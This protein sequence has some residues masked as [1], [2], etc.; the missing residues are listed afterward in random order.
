MSAT[1]RAICQEH[2][3]MFA[4][5][6]RRRFLT[7]TTG[8][9]AGSIFLGPTGR[10]AGLLA[11]SGRFKLSVITDEITQDFA[12]ALEI[13]SREFG[14]HYV[15]IRELWN[16]NIVSLD[17]KEIAEVRSLLDRFQ[18]QVTDIASPF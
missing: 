16:K 17:S 7:T 8:A 11:S 1:T 2:P 6:S 15:E 18:L 3:P 9:A 13:A 12:H 10:G 5:L 4:E 14:L